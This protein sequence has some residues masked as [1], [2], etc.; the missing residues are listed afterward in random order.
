[1]Y[2]FRSIIYSRFK[3]TS[4]TEFHST[5]KILTFEMRKRNL[6]ISKL[7]IQTLNFSIFLTMDDMLS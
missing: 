1:M 7:Y 2:F 4:C 6:L 5:V 3:G